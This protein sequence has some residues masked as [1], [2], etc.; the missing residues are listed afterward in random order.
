MQETKVVLCFE[1]EFDV[2]DEMTG[3]NFQQDFLKVDMQ[4]PP[5]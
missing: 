4:V 5:Q 1:R 2:Q 3:Q